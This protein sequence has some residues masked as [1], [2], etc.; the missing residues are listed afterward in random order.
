MMA[1][2]RI[3]KSINE[4]IG[5]VLDEY[6]KTFDLLDAYDHKTLICPEGTYY[7]GYE[8]LEEAAAELLYMLVKEYKYNKR[9]AAIG[10]LKFLDLNNALFI[11]GKKRI[12]DASLVALIVMIDKSKDEE[13]GQ[14]IK[15]V[16]NC[17]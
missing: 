14:I 2:N 6:N 8:S 10:F 15:L 13:R 17:M 5:L 4:H 7:G 12:S 9:D 16:R 11:E 3:N 1:T